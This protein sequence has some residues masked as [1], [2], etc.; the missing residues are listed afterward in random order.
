MKNC[1]SHPSR[2]LIIGSGI[3]GLSTAIILARL[4]LEVTVLEKNSRPGGLMRGYSREGIECGVGVHYLGSL[5]RGQIL[6][7]FFDYLGVT[8]A[9][10]VVRMG[11]NGVIDR[12]VFDSATGYP[13]IFD[14]PQGMDSYEENLNLAFPEEEKKIAELLV[15]LRRAAQQL[16]G[17]DFLYSAD[18]DFSLLDQSLSLGEIVDELQCSTGLRSVLSIPSCWIGVPPDDET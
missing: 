7:T 1:S 5:G 17:L 15:P 3:G 2:V 9:I 6:R 11:Q 10:P 12:Y 14:L 13:P 16:H 8:E 18:N 4:G